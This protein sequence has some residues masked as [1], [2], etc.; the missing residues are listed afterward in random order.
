MDL[1]IEHLLTQC[2]ISRALKEITIKLLNNHLNKGGTRTIVKP[3][4]ITIS[5]YAILVYSTVDDTFLI[6]IPLGPCRES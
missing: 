3:Q 5:S 4:V 6:T 1:K 2:T